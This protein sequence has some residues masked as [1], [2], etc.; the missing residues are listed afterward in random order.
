MCR[1]NWL[2]IKEHIKIGFIGD[3]AAVCVQVFTLV[4][5]ASINVNSNFVAGLSIDFHFINF[6]ATCRLQY[7]MCKLQ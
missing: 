5:N 7:C 4:A 2:I 1:R 6:P 3:Y